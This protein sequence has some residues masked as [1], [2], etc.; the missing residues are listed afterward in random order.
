MILSPEA[1]KFVSSAKST[2]LRKSDTLHKSLMYNINKI[3][4]NIEPWG[5][6]QV[7]SLNFESTLL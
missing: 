5:T 3:G 6:P 2:N 7:I 1:N 4:P